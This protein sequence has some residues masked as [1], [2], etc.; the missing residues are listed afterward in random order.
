MSGR[1]DDTSNVESRQPHSAEQF[2][3]TIRRA[4]YQRLTIYEVAESEL[5]L[6][7]RGAPD[8]ILFTVGVAALTLAVTLTV[9][10][11]TASFPVASVHTG[12]VALTVVGYVAG[13]ILL[14]IWS[15]SKSA[16]AECVFGI[17]Q[18]LPPDWVI[19]SVETIEED[20]PEA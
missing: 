13:I 20:R 5:E 9:T 7:E 10:L 11:F 4:R 6:L 1:N 14:I 18:R 16:I 2:Q 19:E 15:R 17:K 12:V 3:P 8:S